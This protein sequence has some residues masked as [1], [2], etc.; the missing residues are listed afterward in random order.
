MFRK[1]ATLN[2][3]PIILT[4]KKQKCKIQNLL[5]PNSKFGFRILCIVILQISISNI[6]FRG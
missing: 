3:S 5:K 4:Y 1:C 2:N 6:L